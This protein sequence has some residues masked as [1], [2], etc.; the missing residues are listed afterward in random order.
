MNINTIIEKIMSNSIANTKGD[1]DVNDNSYL[2]DI[3]Q[4]P[5]DSTNKKFNYGTKFSAGNSI[6]ERYHS[7]LNNHK[8]PITY[9]IYRVV[10]YLLKLIICCFY[11]VATF[12]R[13]LFIS[14]KD[15]E[16]RVLDVSTSP[17][18]NFIVFV[19]FIVSYI[20]LIVIILSFFIKSVLF[21][22]PDTRIN[23]S[24]AITMPQ[25]CERENYMYLLNSATYWGNSGIK[26]LEGDEV[27]I[28][29]SGSFFSKIGEMH[30]SALNNK[31]PKYD[32]TLVSFDKNKNQQADTDKSKHKNL[33]VANLKD[34]KSHVNDKFGSLLI[35]IRDNS[36]HTPFHLGDIISDTT[37]SSTDDA[38]HFKA[39][40]SGY[41]HFAVNDEY[42]TE[43]WFEDSIKPNPEIQSNLDIN[44]IAK[45][46]VKDFNYLVN[47]VKKDNE[48]KKRIEVKGK[49]IDS[50]LRRDNDSIDRALTGYIL[51]KFNKANVQ[52]INVN[53]LVRSSIAPW[54]QD[55]L[56]INN[57]AKVSV[58]RFT[59]HD[60]IYEKEHDYSFKSFPIRYPDSIQ[61]NKPQK[62]I[63][64][65]EVYLTKAC[66]NLIRYNKKYRDSIG[67][68]SDTIKHLTVWDRWNERI[69]RMWYSDNVG[70]ILINI[71]IKRQTVHG[72][73]LEP[74]VLSK[75]YREIEDFFLY[76]PFGNR[77]IIFI[78][79]ILLILVGW[80]TFDRKYGEK[81][82]IWINDKLSGRFKRI[83]S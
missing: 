51:S 38:F 66:Y 17:R 74:T 40:K 28:T 48:K 60:S 79:C 11:R 10:V 25:S 78:V 47:L 15:S 61:Y 54:L 5:K 72:N 71:R 76:P 77:K 2:W 58:K 65:K 19:A 18:F 12:I 70:D 36:E 73:I 16:K 8:Y 52:K 35:Q 80:M 32:R 20:V 37:S 21:F 7:S 13:Q 46:P 33:L 31:L 63:V 56:K 6:K 75:T 26:V 62:I 4:N 69:A 45:L 55:L 34:P 82:L 49:D 44:N 64:E 3:I 27:I 59:I 81:V 42:I 22:R 14:D 57:Y 43:S 23:E 50:I 24:G 39:E 68:S 83:L 30:Y 1:I 29:V 67:W 53:G 41:L 9:F